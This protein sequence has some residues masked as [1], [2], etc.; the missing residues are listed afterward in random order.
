MIVPV[1]EQ[2]FFN[3]PIPSWKFSRDIL[4][5]NENTSVEKYIDPELFES[6]SFDTTC[7]FSDTDQ[8]AI[9]GDIDSGRR[10]YYIPGDAS[11]LEIAIDELEGERWF[12]AEQ[13]ALDAGW[14]RPPV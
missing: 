2:P 3:D 7:D 1:N 10:V 8:P 11:Y 4:P 6:S 9:K 13:T 14:R 5:V 12:C